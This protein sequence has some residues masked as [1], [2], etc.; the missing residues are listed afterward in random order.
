MALHGARL[1]AWR[2]AERH[3]ILLTGFGCLLTM[4]AGGK[5]R[6]EE[7]SMSP[8]VLFGVRWVHFVAG[9]TWIGLLYWFNLVNV[10]FQRVVDASLKAQVNPPL[11]TRAL[12]WFRHSAWVTILA[13]LLLIYG[14]YWQDGHVVDT[15]SAKT[16]LVGALLGITML[17]NV[18]GVIWPSQRK[19]L[20]AMA[21]GE[22][23]DPAWPRNALYAS[24]ANF[25]LSFPMLA[26]M[27][28]ASHYPLDWAGI[29]IVGLLLAAI[30]LAV[31]LS[32]Q[33]WTAARF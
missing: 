33:Q 6:E 8:E 26:F 29:V 27:A 23:P 14:L 32:V 7:R 11:L 20:A 2:I 17:I 3:R 12:A 21:A 16:I 1:P 10:P 22:K 4:Q 31:V 19:V 28:G 5:P 25:A 15:N 30:G 18:W 24:R 9:I 13:G